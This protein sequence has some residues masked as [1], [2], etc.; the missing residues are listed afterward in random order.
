LPIWL[1]GL[2][3]QSTFSLPPPIFFSYIL[4]RAVVVV[5]GATD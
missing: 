5:E 3:D 1:A 2:G 4:W